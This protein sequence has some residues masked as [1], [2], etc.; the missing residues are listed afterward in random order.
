MNELHIYL[1]IINA[2]AYLLF[3]I[4]KSKASKRQWRIKES[5]LLGVCS[6]GGAIGG[7]LGMKSFRHKTKKPKFSLGVPIMAACQIALYIILVKP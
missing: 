4:D 1:L 3:G 5:Y 7:I 2:L 6:I